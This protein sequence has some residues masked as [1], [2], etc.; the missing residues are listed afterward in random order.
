MKIVIPGGSGFWGKSLVQ[1]FA[2]QGHDLVILSRKSGTSENCRSVEWDGETLGTWASE[3]DGADAVINLSGRSVNCRA[4]PNNCR[5]MI[6]SRVLST[7]VIGEAIKECDKPPTVWMNSSTATI[8][9]HRFDQPNDEATGLYGSHP[10]GKDKY[11]LE[12][13]DA[14]E[15]AFTKVDLKKTRK[16]I[17]R[18]A[19][20]LGTEEGGVYRVLRRLARFGLGGKM[21]TGKQLVSWIHSDDFCAIV[22]HFI[23]SQNST[24]TYNLCSPNPLPNS[25][26]M[27][28]FRSE[29]SAK[30]GLP[31]YEWM[32]E[33]GAFFMR[34]ETELIIKSRYVV[35]GRLLEENYNFKFSMFRQAIHDIETQL[36]TKSE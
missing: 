9:R 13:A 36:K 10:E 12:I 21:G 30:I 7:R 11:S 14:W 24:G 6:N 3:L 27:K 19:F 22:D 16:I 23:K 31:A 28:A 20:V 25:E 33:I 5:Q 4:T 17:L 34:T 26:M 29:L 35:P 1:Y 32:L 8:Y 2:N 15:N 18:T